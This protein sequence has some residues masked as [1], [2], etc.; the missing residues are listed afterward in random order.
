MAEE[1]LKANKVR[2]KKIK[3]GD[4]EF[5]DLIDEMLADLVRQDMERAAEEARGKAE[6]EHEASAP[7]VRHTGVDPLKNVPRATPSQAERCVVMKYFVLI[8]T[9]NKHTEHSKQKPIAQNLAST[10][11]V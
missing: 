8:P 1:A 2:S 11:R 3:R 10:C 9:S 6:K 4:K 7:G 5:Q